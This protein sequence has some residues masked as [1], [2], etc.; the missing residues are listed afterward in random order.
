[1]NVTNFDLENLKVDWISFNL[2]GLVDPR[3]IAIHLLKYFTPHVLIDDVPIIGFHGFRKRYKVSIH[4]Y[5]GSKGC[6]IGTKIIF[7]GKNA[8]YFYKLLK[9]RNFDWSLLKFEEHT[10][11]LGQIDLCFSRPNDW[12]H[13]SKTFIFAL[14]L[15]CNL[16]KI[17]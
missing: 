16:L 13:T 5:I 6:W 9:T 12:S 11:S 15:L 7:S 14:F 17:A 1:M 3:I 8:S 4:Q 2:E 10:L